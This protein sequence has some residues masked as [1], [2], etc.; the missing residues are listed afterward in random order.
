MRRRKNSLYQIGVMYMDVYGVHIFRK[1]PR[2]PP[3]P[4]ADAGNY[5]PYKKLVCLNL[6]TTL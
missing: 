5:I 2:M 3:L 6:R 1:Q 4:L